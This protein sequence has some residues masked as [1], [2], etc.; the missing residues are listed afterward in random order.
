MNGWSK[1]LVLRW[2]HGSIE[3]KLVNMFDVEGKVKFFPLH[4]R[5]VPDAHCICLP[6]SIIKQYTIKIKACFLSEY[7]SCWWTFVCR[8]VEAFPHSHPRIAMFFNLFY[9]LHGAS[10]WFTV[11]YISLSFSSQPELDGISNRLTGSCC[12]SCC[13]CINRCSI[14]S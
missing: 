14:S 3:G 6:H 11:Y 9:V 13:R 8:G 4:G 1:K 7:L 2:L 12:F 5:H 10:L